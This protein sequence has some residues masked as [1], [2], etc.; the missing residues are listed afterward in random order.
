MVLY[1]AFSFRNRERKK[2]LKFKMKLEHAAAKLIPL[3]GDIDEEE[4]P[5]SSQL[6]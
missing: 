2:K 1:S 6:G 4:E 5:R 3:I